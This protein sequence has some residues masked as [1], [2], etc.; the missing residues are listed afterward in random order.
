M[1]IT[2]ASRWMAATAA[3]TALMCASA[4][5]LATLGYVADENNLSIA[6]VVLWAVFLAGVLGLL[7]SLPVW[8]AKRH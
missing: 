3:S 8:L 7:V 2:T 6:P 4:V 5:G 1:S